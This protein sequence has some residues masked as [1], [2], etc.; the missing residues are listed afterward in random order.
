VTEYNSSG[1]SQLTFGSSGTGN[2][3]LSAPKGMA[4]H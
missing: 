4:I 2:G 3:Q 1:I